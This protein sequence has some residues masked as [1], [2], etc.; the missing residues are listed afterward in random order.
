MIYKFKQGK[1]YKS[2][3]SDGTY[4]Y[5]EVNNIYSEVVNIYIIKDDDSITSL[6]PET[7]YSV[8]KERLFLSK[9]NVSRFTYA[10]YVAMML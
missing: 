4:M 6:I 1:R 8:N 3:N 10:E 2:K 5:F 7:N 9:N